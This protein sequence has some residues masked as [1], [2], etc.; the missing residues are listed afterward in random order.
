MAASSSDAGPPASSGGEAAAGAGA[1][2]AAAATADS[3]KEQVRPTRWFA[4]I[5]GS[6]GLLLTNPAP[7]E[8]R[9][10]L[11]PGQRQHPHRVLDV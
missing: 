10:A 7:C 3:Y 8:Q 2:P 9:W 4:L 1:A 5:S 11:A 6:A